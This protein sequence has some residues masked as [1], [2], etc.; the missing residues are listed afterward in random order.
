MT[1]DDMIPVRARRLFPGPIFQISIEGAPDMPGMRFDGTRWVDETRPDRPMVPIIP[2]K[3][4]EQW[5]DLV[6]S[7]IPAQRRAWL[8]RHLPPK[9]RKSRRRGGF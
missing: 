9:K 2:Q 5:S 3:K 4:P 6:V 1:D 7:M 8:E